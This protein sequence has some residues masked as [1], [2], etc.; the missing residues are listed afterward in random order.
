MSSIGTIDERAIQEA[1]QTQD[2]TQSLID[3]LGMG[4]RQMAQPKPPKP[5]KSQIY[6]NGDEQRQRILSPEGVI[7]SDTAT[8]IRK[9]EHDPIKM[10]SPDKKR[11]VTVNKLE[12]A[13]L[14]R[15]QGYQK[16]EDLKA[17]K[18][19]QTQQGGGN[20][21]F[22]SLGLNVP[23]GGANPQP[24]PTPEDMAKAN[25]TLSKKQRDYLAK[26]RAELAARK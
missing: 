7:I 18:S 3:S 22:G 26:K 20:D 10:V 13:A 14:E 9:G 25:Q 2:S 23:Q 11:I 1:A 16:L 21:F 24:V 12:A 17:L 19:L 6:Y 5:N 4:R 15:D 8:G